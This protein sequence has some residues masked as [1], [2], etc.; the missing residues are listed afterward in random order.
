MSFDARSLERL[1]Q[2]G[3]SLPQPLPKPAPER[4]QA[5]APKLHRLETEQDPEAL[6]R[7]LMQASADGSVPPHLMQRL[8]QLEQERLARQQA[9]ARRPISGESAGRA[10]PPANG[11]TTSQANG[12]KAGRQASRA[13][14]RGSSGLGQPDPRT[15]AEHGELYR[16]FQDLLYLASDEIDGSE[17]L[18]LQPR[19]QRK[20]DDRLRP[21]PADRPRRDVG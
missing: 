14:R 2:L 8:R 21:K 10:N 17:G 20:I 13:F 18:Q 15:A 19:E 9:V 7:E 16:A 1:K 4:P 5:A 6:F 12:A 3:R 11:A